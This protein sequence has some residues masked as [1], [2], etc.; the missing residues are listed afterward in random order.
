MGSS[1]RLAN[2]THIPTAIEEHHQYVHCTGGMFIIIE[3]TH[4]SSPS[5]LP[6]EMNFSRKFGNGGK[7]QRSAGSLTRKSTAEM[8][9]DYIARQTSQTFNQNVES[10]HEVGF[11]WSWNFMSSR[12][13]RSSNTG[14]EHFQDRVLSDFRAFCANDE[15]RLQTFWNDYKENNYV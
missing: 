7:E 13:W 11:L 2:K 9:K 1:V 15:N 12:R 6:K 14:D 3:G 5:P 4:M 8:R 10:D